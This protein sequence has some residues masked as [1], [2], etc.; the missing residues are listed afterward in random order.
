MVHRV[1]TFCRKGLIGLAAMLLIFLSAA[2]ILS[3]IPT[4]PSKVICKKE[5]VVYVSSNG[6]HLD[7]IIAKK[8]LSDD[9]IRGL[10]L[11]RKVAYIAIGW[12]DRDFYINTPTWSDLDFSTAFKALFM[13]SKSAI[14]VVEIERVRK[15][16]VEVPLCQH[17]LDRLIRYVDGTFRKTTDGAFIEIEAAGYGSRDRFYEAK[18]SFSCINTCNNW[19]NQGLKAAEVSTS[20]WSPFDKGVLYQIR[21]HAPSSP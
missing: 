21:N 15:H 7:F 1:I 5:Q 3:I 13:S 12:G 18:G 20:I 8:Q 9:I 6:V 2:A 11:P 17:Q 4:S 19:V 14:H 16:W 10:R